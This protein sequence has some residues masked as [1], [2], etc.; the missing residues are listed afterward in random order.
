MRRNEYPPFFT[1]FLST[2]EQRL[3]NFRTK[4]GKSVVFPHG[5]LLL[6]FDWIFDFRA[7]AASWVFE[8]EDSI[9]EK[10]CDRDS[11]RAICFLMSH[12]PLSQSLHRQSILPLTSDPGNTSLFLF[13]PP[14]LPGV[15]GTLSLPE[16]CLPSDGLPTPP[17]SRLR[18]RMT[19][20]ALSRLFLGIEYSTCGY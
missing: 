12:M 19:A 14:P 6:F 17:A 1:A 7:I 4:A 18:L 9:I 3:D 13:W 20:Y 10:E 16:N 8:G 2:D 11:F 5:C 15:D